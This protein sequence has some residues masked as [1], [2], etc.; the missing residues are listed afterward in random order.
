[1]HNFL[2]EKKEKNIEDELENAI[3]YFENK[4]YN[5]LVEALQCA[6]GD[7]TVLSYEQDVKNIVK[8]MKENNPSPS[9]CSDCSNKNEQSHSCSSLLK[10]KD[11]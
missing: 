6:L 9:C 5:N 10:E 1:M 3:I 11:L 2:L 7:A 4:D 8:Y